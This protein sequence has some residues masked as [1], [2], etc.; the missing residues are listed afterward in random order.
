M[1]FESQLVNLTQLNPARKFE[2]YLE[3]LGGPFNPDLF[4]HVKIV[5]NP[6]G[7]LYL[8]A[9]IIDLNNLDVT[10]LDN[11]F[12]LFYSICD[13]A[14]MWRHKFNQII[15]APDDMNVDDFFS[16]NFQPPSS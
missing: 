9:T 15:A 14:M 12:R 8:K 11:Y 1:Q 16:S 7:A 6:N 10:Q 13:E 4:S 3:A 2:C 5:L